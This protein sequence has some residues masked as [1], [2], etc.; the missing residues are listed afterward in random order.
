[1]V[2]IVPPLFSRNFNSIKGVMEIWHLFSAMDSNSFP[3]VICARFAITRLLYEPKSFFEEFFHYE[4]I[5][6]MTLNKFFTWRF[7]DCN[8]FDSSNSLPKINT[9]MTLAFPIQ[10]FILDNFKSIFLSRIEASVL[11]IVCTF[12]RLEY[13]WD[14]IWR[15]L[16]FYCFIFFRFKR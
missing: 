6:E 10:I 16:T 2:L 7:F 8:R 5:I 1:M 9:Q 14:L 15:C 12:L 13:L 3:L 11:S 4:N